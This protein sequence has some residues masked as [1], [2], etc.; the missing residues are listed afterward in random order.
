MKWF[1]QWFFDLRKRKERLKIVAQY[2]RAADSYCEMAALSK[3]VKDITWEEYCT[4][5]SSIRRADAATWRK[6]V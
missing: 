2:E 4:L 3:G 5:M 1:L 6:L